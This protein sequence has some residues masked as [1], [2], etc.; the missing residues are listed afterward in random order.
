ME[1]RAYYPMQN[2]LWWIEFLTLTLFIFWHGD[3]YIA[4][5]TCFLKIENNDAKLTQVLRGLI[6]VT[7]KEVFK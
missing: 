5:W 3:I 7:I 2:M 6:T 4:F 1:V